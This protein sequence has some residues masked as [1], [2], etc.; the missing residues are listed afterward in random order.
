MAGGYSITIQAVDKASGT[1]D[2]VNKRPEA[3]SKRFAHAAAPF[4]RLEQSFDKFT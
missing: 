1:F 3:M 4:T 2:A